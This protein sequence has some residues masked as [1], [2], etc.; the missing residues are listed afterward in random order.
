MCRHSISGIFRFLI[1]T[2]CFSAFPLFAANEFFSYSYVKNNLSAANLKGPVKSIKVY[3]VSNYFEYDT[4]L[5]YEKLGKPL[6]KYNRKLENSAEFDAEGR[7]TRHYDSFFQETD[8]YT[9]HPD[10]PEW[11]QYVKQETHGEYSDRI[12]TL[13][14]SADGLPVSGTA[15]RPAGTIFNETFTVIPASDG[16]RILL[17]LHINEEDGRAYIDT[18]TFRKDMSLSSIAMHTGT[19]YIMDAQ[20]RPI[21]LFSPQRDGSIKHGVIEYQRGKRLS[22]E[23]TPK[24]RVLIME[25][26]FDKHNNPIKETRYSSDGSP[27]YITTYKYDYDSHGNWIRRE[28]KTGGVEERVIEYHK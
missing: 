19:R 22:F 1:I 6:P 12:Y 8:I 4:I 7:L 13:E 10:H 2:I 15:Y 18:M 9:Y 26:V 14:R 20:E 27:S 17:C 28:N 11:T 25:T 16:S 23:V 21:E 24:G 5:K 3:T